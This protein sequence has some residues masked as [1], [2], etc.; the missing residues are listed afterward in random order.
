MATLPDIEKGD[1]D[2]DE[3]IKEPLLEKKDGLDGLYMILLCTAVAVCGSFAF[4]SSVGYSSPAQYAIMEELGLSYS[5]YSIF[6]SI[7][8]VGAMIGALTCGRISDTVGRKG[9]MRLSSFIC[10]AGWMAIYL[11]KVPKMLYMGRFS[12]GYSVGILSY[13]IPVFVGEITPNKLRGAIGSLNQLFIVIGLSSSYVIG[14]FAGWRTLALCGLAPCVLQF[15]GLFLI[16]ESPRWLAMSGQEEA[17]EAALRK[18]RGP[19]VDISIEA[20]IVKENVATLQ[21]HPKVTLRNLFDKANIRAVVIAVGLMAFQQVVGIN[22]IVFYSNYIFQ[23][24]G[25]NPNVGSILYAIIQIF[26][27][28][29]NAI[30]VDRTGRRPLLLTSASGL[31]L[32]SLLI[33]M[34]FLLKAHEL[35][36]NWVPYFAVIGVLVYIGFFSIGMGAGPWLIMSEVFSLHIKGLGGGLVTLVNW[37]GSWVVSFTFNFLMLWSSYDKDHIGFEGLTE[38]NLA[39]NHN[40]FGEENGINMRPTQYTNTAKK[41]STKLKGLGFRP[42]TKAIG[43]LEKMPSRLR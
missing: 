32:G 4:G 13:V 25:F 37:F 29:G 24:A 2:G 10:T 35:A 36:T 16:P 14:A 26:V 42:E 41:W 31:L 28:A 9:A 20:G 15:L 1:H 40:I 18:L 5:Q 17:F 43:T 21:L 34:S 33:A 19:H 39:P 6:G 30:L 38:S 11:A 3:L 27:T 8:T 23:S 22:G 12:I 7:L